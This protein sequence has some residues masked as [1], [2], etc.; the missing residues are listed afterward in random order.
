[1]R[2]YEYF[3]DAELTCKCGCGLM[4]HRK[5]IERLYALRILLASPLIV[6][7]GARCTKYNDEVG[8]AKSSAHLS[9][10]AFDLCCTNKSIHLLMEYDLIRLSI[11]VGFTGIGIANNRFLHVDDLPRLSS[12]IWHY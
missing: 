10:T 5:S 2:I 11:M 7:S 6:T 8:G 1:M 12:A 3:T 9:G 4:P